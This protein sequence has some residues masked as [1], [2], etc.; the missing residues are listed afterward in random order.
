MGANTPIKHPVI[1]F[2]GVCNLCNSSINFI[3]QRDKKRR[4]KFS[5]LQGQYAAKVLPL[6]YVGKDSLPSLILF[7]QEAKIKSTA[8]LNI[9]KHLSGLWPVL[10]IFILIPAFIRHFFYDFVAKNRYNWFG[11]KE[12][13]MIPTP[14]LKDR[15]ID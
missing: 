13:C 5:P 10:Y 1:F 2:D 3:I 15:F 14:E 6:K 12:Q 11:R 7:D 4:F 8:A 9:A